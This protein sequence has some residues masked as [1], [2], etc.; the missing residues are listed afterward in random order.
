MGVTLLHYLIMLLV[1]L[2]ERA[3]VRRHGQHGSSH[4]KSGRGQPFLCMWGMGLGGFRNDSDCMEYTTHRYTEALRTWNALRIN[5]RTLPPKLLIFKKFCIKKTSA[6][7]KENPFT[8]K[9]YIVSTHYRCFLPLLEI[10]LSGLSKNLWLF[11][12]KY[13]ATWTVLFWRSRYL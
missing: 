9:C 4:R 7:V 6:P 1:E 5:I 10:L 2:K 8:A 12:N 3:S 11:T 13:K